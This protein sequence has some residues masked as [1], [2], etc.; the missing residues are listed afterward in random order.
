MEK[1]DA[2]GSPGRAASADEDSG[3]ESFSDSE[4]ESSV[5]APSSTVRSSSSTSTSAKSSRSGTVKDKKGKGKAAAVTAKPEGE[6]KKAE[7]TNVNVFKLDLSQVTVDGQVMTG[8]PVFCGKCSVSFSQLSKM[9]TV[10]SAGLR[11]KNAE[12][13]AKYRQ[14]A[15]AGV[16]D[17]FLAPEDVP[18]PSPAPVNAYTSEITDAVLQKAAAQ[19]AIASS[20]AAAA[21]STAPSVSSSTSTTTTTTTARNLDKQDYSTLPEEVSVWTCEFCGFHNLTNLDEEELPRSDSVDY[22]ISP[23]P[24]GGMEEQNVV[25]CVDISGS[26][27]VTTEVQANVSLKGG[28]DS[29]EASVRAHAEGD[30]K[31]PHEKRG[32]KYV[33]RLQCVQA[34]IEQHI[35][36]IAKSK[37]NFRVGL[38]TFSDEVTIVGTSLSHTF[39]SLFYFL[40]PSL[41]SLHPIC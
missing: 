34:A 7:K 26:M 3:D 19:G 31:L 14:P 40:S 29:R 25:F 20:A 6:K 9:A 37:P 5:S 24:A 15:Y 8:D 2:P 22:V 13:C 10:P 27:C 28:A 38:V 16:R 39:L 21:A 1:K 32:V 36:Q 4:L 12:L 33:S 17:L 41:P 30:Q 18:T 11:E 23:A 35:T